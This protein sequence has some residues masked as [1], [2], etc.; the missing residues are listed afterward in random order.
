MLQASASQ[1]SL[2]K[3]LDSTWTFHSP[4]E[5]LNSKSQPDPLSTSSSST[6]STPMGYA[7]LLLAFAFA[8]PLHAAIGE[9][10][11]KTISEEMVKA[12]EKRLFQVYGH[13]PMPLKSSNHPTTY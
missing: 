8:S 9:M 12:F 4:Q 10:F 7:S 3:S 5:I 13:R 11:W 6:T 2:F 1:S